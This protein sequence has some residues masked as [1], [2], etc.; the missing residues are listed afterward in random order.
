MV[1]L[2]LQDSVGVTSFVRLPDNHSPCIQAEFGIF[3]STSTGIKPCDYLYYITC[4]IV[5]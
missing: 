3:N 1:I 2:V 4:N 5:F